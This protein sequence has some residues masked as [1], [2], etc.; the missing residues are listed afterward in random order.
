[1]NDQLKELAAQT[2]QPLD[3]IPTKPHHFLTKKVAILGIVFLLVAV[4]SSVGTA[5]VLHKETPRLE[6]KKS[7]VVAK[8]PVTTPTP[9]PTLPVEQTFSSLLQQQASSSATS[10][11]SAAA[12]LQTA[13]ALYPSTTTW[14]QPQATTVFYTKVQAEDPI[15]VSGSKVQGNGT[16]PSLENMRDVGATYLTANGWEQDNNIAADGPTGSTWGYKKAVGSKMQILE[17]SYTNT[18]LTVT[19]GQPVQSICPC[20][21]TYTVFLSNPF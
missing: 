7:A 14:G 6:T 19:P 3:R 15:Q 16:V 20:N 5:Y 9:K 13:I 18:S 10:Q 12:F 1:M 8:K 4:V 21:V 2:E 17:L 11:A